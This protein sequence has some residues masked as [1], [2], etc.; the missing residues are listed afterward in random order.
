[1]L[2]LKDTEWITTQYSGLKIDI[3]NKCIVG[4]IFLNRSYNEITL[5]NIFSIVIMLEILPNMILP[6]VYETSD[7]LEDIAKKHN[8][9]NIEELHVNSDDSLCLAIYG[10]EKECFS[11][12]FTI[13]EFFENCLDPYLYWITYYDKYAKPPWKEY[14][15]GSLGYIELYAENRL[16]FVEIRQKIPLKEFSK[17]LYHYDFLNNKCLCGKNIS[18]SKCHYDIY[19]GLK[20]FKENWQLKRV[21]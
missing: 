17:Y 1:M 10:R 21:S 15:H 9:S 16:S 4:D 5:T 14:A 20:K 11:D 7:K 6:K 8:L 12:K 19:C 18:M 3:E 2:S 13:K